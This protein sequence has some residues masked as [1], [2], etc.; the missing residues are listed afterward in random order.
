MTCKYFFSSSFKCTPYIHTVHVFSVSPWTS[1]T[2]TS[3]NLSLFPVSKPEWIYPCRWSFGVVLWEIFTLGG[4]PYS[5]TDTQQLFNLLKDGYRLKRPRLCDQNAYVPLSSF[6]QHLF[7]LL[8]LALTLALKHYRQAWP[9]IR[10]NLILHTHTRENE[11]IS[12]WGKIS[13]RDFSPCLPQVRHDAAVL[14]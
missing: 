12:Q 13:E 4:T 8:I 6:L 2:C 11:L 7:N 1:C 9:K 3:R 5:S 10:S 14:E